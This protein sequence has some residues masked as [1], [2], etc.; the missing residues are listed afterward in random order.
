[1]R[2]PVTAAKVYAMIRVPIVPATARVRFNYCLRSIAKPV[3][4]YPHIAIVR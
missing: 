3:I 2:I 4:R 1:M